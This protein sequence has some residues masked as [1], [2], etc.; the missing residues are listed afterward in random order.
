MKSTNCPVP[1]A[2][3]ST[4]R[5][6][7][8]SRGG[9]EA[10][11]KTHARFW[12]V[13]LVALLACACDEGGSGA[14]SPD[15][16]LDVA[17]LGELVG[18][19]L[20]VPAKV[21]ENEPFDLEVRALSSTGGV[22]TDFAG[23]VTLTS[24]LGDLEPNDVM[25]AEGVG[26][27]AATLNRE[28]KA[29][30]A[31]SGSGV[32][33]DSPLSVEAAKWVRE[34]GDD[35]VGKAGKE[36]SWLYAGYYGA[37]VVEAGP[38]ELW[39]YFSAA[40][41]RDPDGLGYSMGRSV[42]SDGGFSW[43]V[44]PPDPLLGATFADT[45]GVV[46][47]AVLRGQDGTFHMWFG[48]VKTG[49]KA[50]LRG[51]RRAHSADGVVWVLDGCP[52]LGVNS[53]PNTSAGVGEPSVLPGTA[54]GTFDLYFTAYNLETDGLVARIARVSGSLSDS[55]AD[56]WQSATYVVDRGAK[57]TWSALR[58]FTPAVWRDGSVWKMLYGGVPR[59]GAAPS[60]GYATSADGEVW[61]T[62]ASNPVL[63]H[64]S[65]DAFGVVSPSVVEGGDVLFFSGAINGDR[66]HLG[67]AAHLP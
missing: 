66:S 62:S 22:Q 7:C 34:P 67:R 49:E 50:I 17:A 28:G 9:V 58:V 43:T 29:A 16:S 47:P 40:N 65:W 37:S 36:T 57:D 63:V 54:D 59:D 56:E 61:V 45:E 13:P 51:I 2:Q 5:V 32:T 55:C 1:E 8:G 46:H 23:K 12:V 48:T 24:D 60:I 39:A 6:G 30:I 14:A 27:V 38:T 52:V 25:L 42:S 19:S 10:A 31:M 44:D 53:F 11:A 3:S 18:F 26:T 4:C 15:V 41:K 35:P 33:S 21:V 20:V 64:T